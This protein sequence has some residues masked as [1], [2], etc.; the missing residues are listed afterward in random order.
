VLEDTLAETPAAQQEKATRIAATITGPPAPSLRTRATRVQ[1]LPS[2]TQAETSDGWTSPDM[3]A[4]ERAA[5]R[6]A[7]RPPSR[8]GAWI[9]VLVVLLL[10][11]AA[12]AAL[13]VTGLGEES[14]PAAQSEAAPGTARPEAA[15]AAAPAV[16]A[17]ALDPAAEAPPVVPTVPEKPVAETA[18]A[19]AEVVIRSTPTGAVVRRGDEELCRTPCDLDLPPEKEPVKL[20]IERSG[21]RPT[22]IVLSLSPGAG[23][24]REVR[25]RR[26][27]PAKRQSA[28]GAAPAA[29]AA[30]PASEKS[31]PARP[32]PRPPAR[33]I[34]ACAPPR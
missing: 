4:A 18:Q 14:V 11:G 32:L 22:E 26:A 28:V 13:V 1:D 24:V 21:Y 25:L 9:G 8:A 6:R 27:R 17:T 30:E 3:A 16:A 33:A 31:A 5:L 7:A 15:P 34:G 19:N 29:K 10:A 23:I 12:I 2:G 20:S